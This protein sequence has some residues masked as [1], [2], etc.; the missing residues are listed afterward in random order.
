VTIPIEDS[1]NP[2]PKHAGAGTRINETT[3]IDGRRPEVFCA[4]KGVDGKTAG[5]ANDL[6]SRIFSECPGPVKPWPGHSR[7]RKRVTKS[8]RQSSR[9]GQSMIRQ[10]RRGLQKYNVIRAGG[11]DERP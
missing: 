9:Q 7:A 4:G 6:F 11:A 8:A 10:S 3:L 5:Y 1:I 2:C